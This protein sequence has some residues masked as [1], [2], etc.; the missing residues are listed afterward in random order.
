MSK[1]SDRD[2]ATADE[3]RA[4]LDYDPETGVFRWRVRSDIPPASNGRYAG[5]VAGRVHANGYVSIGLNY[6]D[7]RAHRLAWMHVNGV[8]PVAEIDHINGNPSDNR[9]ANLREASRQQNLWNIC[10]KSS[11]QSGIKG[12]HFNK[13]TGR[14]WSKIRIDGKQVRL[15]T[16]DTAEEAADAYE[17]AAREH[18]GAFA[19]KSHFLSAA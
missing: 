19:K 4:A 8:W 10:V 16:F 12:A 17:R 6:I 9:I 14:W 11:S 1:R 18:F 3:V 2:L 13:Q 5:K 7:Y 15:G